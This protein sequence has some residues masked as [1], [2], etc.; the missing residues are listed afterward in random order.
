MFPETSF[1]CPKL[2]SDGPLSGGALLATVPPSSRSTSCSIDVRICVCCAFVNVP[3]CRWKSSMICEAIVC[4]IV[5]GGLP[6][7]A[8]ACSCE[9]VLLCVA[10]SA[11]AGT[12]DERTFENSAPFAPVKL[13]SD[14]SENQSWPFAPHADACTAG[15]FS[16]TWVTLYISPPLFKAL[17]TLREAPALRS[18]SATLR[19]KWN[20]APPCGLRRPGP[21]SQGGVPSFPNSFIGSRRWPP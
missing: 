7:C 21:R 11:A 9:S 14:G 20:C 17:R 3:N 18:A 13:P 15:L 19:R 6:L 1:C 10:G 16:C 12:I 8:S 2:C 4:A 5:D